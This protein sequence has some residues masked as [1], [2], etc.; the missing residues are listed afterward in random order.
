VKPEFPRWTTVELYESAES[1]MNINM[2]WLSW[3]S[4]HG[5]PSG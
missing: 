1:A 2:L 3:W 4:V 5:T